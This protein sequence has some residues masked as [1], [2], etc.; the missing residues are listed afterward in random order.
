MIK[1]KFRHII[2]FTFAILLWLTISCPVMADPLHKT[3]YINCKI[4]VEKQTD[5][6]DFDNL[7]GINPL[8]DNE[9]IKSNFLK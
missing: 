5:P 2:N 1:K 6:I 3:N 9:E 7:V 4:T 8:S